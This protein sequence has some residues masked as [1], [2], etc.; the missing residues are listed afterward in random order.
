MMKMILSMIIML[1]IQGCSIYSNKQVYLQDGSTGYRIECEGASP[2]YDKAGE[3]CKGKGFTT[4][5]QTAGRLH[6]GDTNMSM[7]VIKCNR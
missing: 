4:I 1:S 5:E 6:G 7:I 3:I 2:C